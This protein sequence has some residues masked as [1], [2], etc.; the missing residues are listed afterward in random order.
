MIYQLPQDYVL[1]GTQ[2]PETK[3]RFWQTH[4]VAS[5]EISYVE[6]ALTKIHQIKTNGA[7]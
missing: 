5:Q 4:R 1:E 7:M 2:A 3:R 6:F